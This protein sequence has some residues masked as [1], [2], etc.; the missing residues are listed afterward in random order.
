MGTDIQHP[1][2]IQGHKTILRPLCKETDLEACYHWL[3][4]SEVTNFLTIFLPQSKLAESRWFDE[5]PQRKGD[6]VLA[7]ETKSERQFIGV[8][9]LHRI[10]W[11]N[12]IATTGAFIGDKTCW[13]KGYGTDAKMFLLD[14]GF[15]Q[16]NFHKICS[17]V[18]EYNQRSLNY[19]LHCGYKKEGRLRQQVFK[20]GRYWGLILLGLF[21]KNW[22]PIWQ[23]YQK[24]GS[25][26]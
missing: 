21:K 13:G 14:Y 26:K 16:L 22:E 12:R 3:N 7:I 15:N 1:I 4:D 19:S 11:Q 17:Q 6:I 10:D 18:I 23:R 9:G 8:M 5:L 20:K 25:V 2:F 24:T